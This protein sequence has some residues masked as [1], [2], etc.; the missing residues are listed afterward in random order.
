MPITMLSLEIDY[1]KGIH[2][3][4][5]YLVFHVMIK[6]MNFL[7]KTMTGMLCQISQSLHLG[8]TQIKQNY[9]SQKVRHEY[10]LNAIIKPLA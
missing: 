2:L 9:R 8:H 10:F 7:S 4:R 3:N 5:A 6:T 1:I